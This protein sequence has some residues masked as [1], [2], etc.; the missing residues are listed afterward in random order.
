MI[1]IPLIIV[2][3]FFMGVFF[4]YARSD[5]SFSFST[6]L[7]AALIVIGVAC[8]VVNY[9]LLIKTFWFNLLF[10][11]LAFMAPTFLILT[12][13]LS[14]RNGE[15]KKV[16]LPIL[17]LMAV[18]LLLL[19]PYTQTSKLYSLAEVEVV[20]D[21]KP[22]SIDMTHIRQVNYEYAKWKADKIVGEMG[23]KVKLGELEIM[24]YRGR[25]TWVAPLI[26][27]GFWKA[28][29]YEQTSGYIMVDAENPSLEAKMY[30]NYSLDISYQN[31]YFGDYVER[32]I[33]SDYSKYRQHWS[34]E[35]DEDGKP[36]IIC[37]LANPTVFN[38]GDRLDKV[39]VISP[40][41]R[42]IREFEV[43]EQPDWIE[44]V[45][46]E[47]L[48]ESYCMWWGKYKHGFWNTIFSEK[49]VK[50][51][52]SKNGQVDVFM[53]V[54]KDNE[55]YWFTDFTSPS[56][57]DKSMM[58]YMLINTKTG[59]FTFY[60][61]NGLLNGDAAMEAATA[62]VR[63]FKGWYATQPIFLILGGNETWFTPIHSGTNILQKFAIIQAMDGNVTMGD[64]LEETLENYLKK[65]IVDW[66][67][68]SGSNQISGVVRD[69]HSY[70]RYGETEWDIQLETDNG[71]VSVYA[72]ADAKPYLLEPTNNVIIQYVTADSHYFE[73]VKIAVNMTVTDDLQ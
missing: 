4:A 59:E 27:R 61:A 54:G 2:A 66:R 62:K 7:L 19:A 30:S 41:T 71:T 3:G 72:Y 63:N 48:A 9:F 45:F 11:F 8:G 46:P 28:R 55:S 22:L 16:V 25:L 29:E 18:F 6:P 69:I 24:L 5:K 39:L 65:E 47:E 64:T 12:I 32:I 67:T 14:A 35:I 53:V 52:T 20:E 42:E 68:I 58:G 49:D 23:N 31:E 56:S 50:E 36:W 70:V 15:P 40:E 44:N 60:K 1:L 17:C 43:G 21:E 38:K 57:D 10:V 26:H 34:F 37:T 13:V 33:Y 73:N 51:P